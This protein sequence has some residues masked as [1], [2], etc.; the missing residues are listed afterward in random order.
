ME[1]HIGYELNL[2][3]V[4]IMIIMGIVLVMLITGITLVM[5]KIVIVIIVGYELNSV[6]VK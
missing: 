1:A 2:V 3:I 4:I 5:L 6:I